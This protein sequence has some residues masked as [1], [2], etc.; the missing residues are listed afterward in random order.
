MYVARNRRFSEVFFVQI[1][2]VIEIIVVVVEILVE[3]IV[4]I[5][6]DVF[7]VIIVFAEEIGFIVV[8]F[9]SWAADW[10]VE[11][12]LVWVLGPSGGRGGG[13]FDNG[14]CIGLSDEEFDEL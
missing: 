8:E 3:I 9:V 4:I 14:A 12:G 5:V 10:G 13:W 2:I 11:G 7:V 6:K 1:D